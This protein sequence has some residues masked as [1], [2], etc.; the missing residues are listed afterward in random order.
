MRILELPSWYSSKSQIGRKV[1]SDRR[2]INIH[3]LSSSKTPIVGFRK[4]ILNTNNAPVQDP[5]LRKR[6][7]VM[8]T[9]RPINSNL[10]GFTYTVAL[11]D[12]ASRK[13]IEYSKTNL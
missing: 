4:K 5:A 10:P 12:C 8:V 3:L 2:S 7:K 9:F 13:C 1:I 11:T 6:W